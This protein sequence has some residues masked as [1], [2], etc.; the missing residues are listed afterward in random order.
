MMC[1]IDNILWNTFLAN[2]KGKSMERILKT[3]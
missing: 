3:M 1:V 2:P